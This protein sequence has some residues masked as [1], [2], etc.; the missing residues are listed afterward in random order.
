MY[1]GRSRVDFAHVW[2]RVQHGSLRIWEVR[3]EFGSDVAQ[4][5]TELEAALQGE[6]QGSSINGSIHFMEAGPMHGAVPRV[7][8]ASKWSCE[9]VPPVTEAMQ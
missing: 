7:E 1:D 5:Q 2:E 3:C 9:V 4:C 8:D 6:A